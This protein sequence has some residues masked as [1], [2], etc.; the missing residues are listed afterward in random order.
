MKRSSLVVIAAL[1][2]VGSISC[3]K[4]GSKNT[5]PNTKSESVLIKITLTPVPGGAVKGDFDAAVYALL[6]NS[7]YATWKVNNVTRNNETTLTFTQADFQNGV[8]TLE[9]TANV[10]AA[11]LSMGGITT[12]PYPYTVLVEPTINGKA[13]STSTISVTNTFT[14][15]LT[16]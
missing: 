6:P 14:R 15:D 11:Y 3:K 4:S 2:T 9:T 1:L 16:Y 7:Q 13:D 12:A 5:P 8:L 10:T